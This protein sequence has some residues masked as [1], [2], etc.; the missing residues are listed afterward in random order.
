MKMPYPAPPADPPLA[1]TPVI[2]ES[3][4]PTI[5]GT[6]PAA[7]VLAPAR[8]PAHPPTAPERM[9]AFLNAVRRQRHGIGDLDVREGHFVTQP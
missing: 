8:R 7:G 3:R 9:A 5:G 4:H 2:R 6:E 1:A